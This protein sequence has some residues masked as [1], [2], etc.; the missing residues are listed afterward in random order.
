MEILKEGH[1]ELVGWHDPDEHRQWVREN[2][3]RELKDKRMTVSEAVEKF[4]HDGDFIACGGFGHVRI[5]MALIYEIIRQGKR[6][7]TM[8]GKTAVHDIDILIGAGCVSRVE[9][10]YAFGHELRGLSPAGR[11]A[12]ET[13]KC[14]VVAEISNAGYQWR[15]LA[16]AMGLPFIPPAS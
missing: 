16:A 9:V 12:V 5:P 7:L 8:A 11:R 13:G 3:S 14:K 4:V 15:F 10:A 6:N 2:K 1:G